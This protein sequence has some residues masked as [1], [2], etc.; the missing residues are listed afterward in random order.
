MR[1][2]E[3]ITEI[4][5]APSWGKSSEPDA[6]RLEKLPANVQPLKGHPNF[7]YH[8]YRKSSIGWH[9]GNYQVLEVLEK[10]TATVAGLL[11]VQPDSSLLREAVQVADVFVYKNYQGQGLASAMYYTLAVDRGR[12]IVA[13]QDPEGGQTP[14]ARKMWAA[15]SEGLPGVIIKGWVRIDINGY[16]FQHDENEEDRVVNAIM[17]LGGEWLWHTKNE[18]AILFDVRPN[19][20]GREL[21]A[22]VNNFLSR[23]VYTGES[24][25]EYESG[26]VMMS[27]QNYQRV[28]GVV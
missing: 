21:T 13:D 23:G 8:T 18:W 14:Q 26:L 5:R 25:G 1:V 22:V 4:T 16:D 28:T 20:N 15:M 24:G 3:F 11:Y 9:H 17:N 27:E 2:K 10:K 6:P 19:S 7:V 12:I